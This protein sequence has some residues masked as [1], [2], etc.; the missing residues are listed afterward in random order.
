MRAEQPERDEFALTL[1]R[2]R[3]QVGRDLA[4]LLD[5]ASLH[6]EVRRQVARV[7]GGLSS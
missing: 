2:Q 7:L 5:L 1:L 4:G 3:T 6:P